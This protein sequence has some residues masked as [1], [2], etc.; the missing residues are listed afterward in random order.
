MRRVF[1]NQL[2]EDVYRYADQRKMISVRSLLDSSGLS[3]DGSYL[4]VASPEKAF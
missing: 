4:A 2:Y 3:D 1:Y